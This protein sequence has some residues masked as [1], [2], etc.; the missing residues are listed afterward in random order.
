MVEEVNTSLASNKLR[1][2][3]VLPPIKGDLTLPLNQA[4]EA[5]AINILLV[6]D[7]MVCLKIFSKFINELGHRV[8]ACINAESALTLIRSR[9]TRFDCL[10]MDVNLPNM[11]AIEA[12]QF[13]KKEDLDMK[14]ILMSASAEYEDEAISCGANAFIVKPFKKFDLENERNLMW[15]E[16][17]HCEAF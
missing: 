4:R 14:V 10:L 3:A 11:T 2:H 8:V 9:D 12:M 7:S 1:F 17:V 15:G 13:I 16:C 5:S 6:D